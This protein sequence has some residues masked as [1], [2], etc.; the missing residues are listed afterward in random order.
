MIMVFATC[1]SVGYVV[2][3][4]GNIIDS[5]NDAAKY[6]ACECV[7][8][9]TI[10]IIALIVWSVALAFSI[11]GFIKCCKWLNNFKFVSFCTVVDKRETIEMV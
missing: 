10:D 6:T 9:R 11:G 2:L 5:N 4:I 1:F 3:A 8:L 7:T